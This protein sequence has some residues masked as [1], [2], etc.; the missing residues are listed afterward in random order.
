MGTR[1]RCGTLA[2]AG[3]L[4]AGMLPVTATPAFATVFCEVT[5]TGDG[6]VAL[7]AKPDSGGKLLLKVKAGDDVQIDD[8]RKVTRGWQPVI[9]RG[10][11]RTGNT[12]GW[13]RAKLLSTE[14]G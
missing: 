10:P 13:M 6:F 9:W 14:C 4:H 2:L 3:L 7:R 1:N 11:D 12:T 8:T 5:S